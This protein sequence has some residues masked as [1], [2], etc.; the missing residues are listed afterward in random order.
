MY[1]KSWYGWNNL[2]VWEFY[3]FIIRNRVFDFKIMQ[4]CM[5]KINAWAYV[6]YFC[7]IHV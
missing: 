3:S 1:R 5:E 2:N 6:A 4:Y 7:G